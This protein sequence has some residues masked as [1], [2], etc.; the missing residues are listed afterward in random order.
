MYRNC[1][2]VVLLS[3]VCMTLYTQKSDDFLIAKL[4]DKSRFF[5][6]KIDENDGVIR[7]RI[8]TKD[9]IHIDR[10]LTKNVYEEGNAVVFSDGKY[11]ETKGYFWT[12]AFGNNIASEYVSSHMEFLFAY[13][14]TPRFSL[15]LG[16]GFEFNEVEAAGFEFD[17]QYSSIFGYGRFNITEGKRRFFSFARLGSGFSAEEN[18]QGIRNEQEGGINGMYGFGYYSASRSKSRFQIILG[19]YFQQASGREFFLDN[20]G[21]QIETKY[22]L[23][24]SRLILK[25]GWE[26]G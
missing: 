25:F 17:T 21:N 7:L 14:V 12:F 22:D 11:F 13:R 26:F 2:L 1:F 5:G 16:T 9:T 20:L 4:H 19:Q 6:E 3:L 23:L 10:R 18:V 24:I 15:G 8:I